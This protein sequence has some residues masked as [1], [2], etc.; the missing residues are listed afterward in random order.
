[1]YIKRLRSRRL[2]RSDGGS[3]DGNRGVRFGRSRTSL[4]NGCEVQTAGFDLLFIL[5][6]AKVNLDDELRRS[7][8]LNLLIP[9]STLSRYKSSMPSILRGRTLSSTVSTAHLT[10]VTIEL[11]AANSILLEPANE[12]LVADVREAFVFQEFGQVKMSLAIGGPRGVATGFPR[13]HRTVIFEPL[14]SCFS[15]LRRFFQL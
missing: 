6:S 4:S 12:F 13:F 5:K 1:M 14:E 15:R 9:E 2:T 7:E 10:I 11:T 8:V 3:G